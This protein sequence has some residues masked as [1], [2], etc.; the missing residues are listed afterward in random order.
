MKHKYIS[1]YIS[2]TN[3]RLYDIYC[4]L[5]LF[6]HHSVKLGVLGSCLEYTFGQ[7]DWHLLAS[8]PSK[9]ILSVGVL[10]VECCL[11]VGLTLDWPGQAGS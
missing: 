8:P 6:L 3:T 1:Q 2:H 7:L 5:G 9:V 4:K 10:E 11:L